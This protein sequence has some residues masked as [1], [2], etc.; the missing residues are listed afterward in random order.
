MLTGKSRA[1]PKRFSYIPFFSLG[2]FLVNKLNKVLEPAFIHRPCPYLPVLLEQPT[3][4]MIVSRMKLREEERNVFK[5][6]SLTQGSPAMPSDIAPV[7]RIYRLAAEQE[8]FR[9][10]IIL[11]HATFMQCRQNWYYLADQSE[12]L[13]ILVRFIPYIDE[14]QGIRDI[15]KRQ[16]VPFG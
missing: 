9:M 4:E 10:D 13:V 3:N 12:P 6:L 2:S 16:H 14:V 8:I 11:D 1:F 7:N 5:A 15:F